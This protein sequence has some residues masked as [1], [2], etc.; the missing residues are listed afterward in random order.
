MLLRM[1]EMFALANGRR[2]VFALMA[3]IA[4]VVGIPELSMA[5]WQG[6]LVSLETRDCLLWLVVQLLVV[7]VCAGL[8]VGYKLEPH[9][10]AEVIMA[11]VLTVSVLWLF[12][13][14]VHGLFDK[15]AYV[16]GVGPMVAAMGALLGRGFARDRRSR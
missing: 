13:G 7:G 5:A 9:P 6:G 10:K 12:N 3:T 1:R 14:E 16:L 8:A 4:V 15:I 11:A 2:S